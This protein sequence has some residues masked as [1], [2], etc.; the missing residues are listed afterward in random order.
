MKKGILEEG[1]HFVQK[2]LRSAE[3]LNK[4]RE[5]LGSSQG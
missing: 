1:I 5:V 4:I 2:P 3:L